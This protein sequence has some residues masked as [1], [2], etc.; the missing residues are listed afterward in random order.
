[1][2]GPSP[3]VRWCWCNPR[4]TP[5]PHQ[6]GPAA[7]PPTRVAWSVR[8]RPAARDHPPGWMI[9]K[10]SGVGCCWWPVEKATIARLCAHAHAR[11]ESVD[12]WLAA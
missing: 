8:L 4:D 6:T 3:R 10:P 9:Y 12:P 7:C 2:T 1:M 11:G 5:H